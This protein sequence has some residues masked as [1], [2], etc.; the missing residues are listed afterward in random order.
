LSSAFSDI[1]F[2]ENS[3]RK[4]PYEDYLSLRLTD[5]DNTPY[6]ILRNYEKKCSNGEPK[7]FKGDD[8]STSRDREQI[9]S[10]IDRIDEYESKADEHGYYSY[11]INR[12]TFS[13]VLQIILRVFWI[14][15]PIVLSKY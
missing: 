11:H 6:T 12:L 8:N 14:C 1:V 15:G 7:I 10:L 3:D 5:T 2:S 13:I 4:H 9:N